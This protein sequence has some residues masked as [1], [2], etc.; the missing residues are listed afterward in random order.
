MPSRKNTPVTPIIDFDDPKSLHVAFPPKVGFG[1]VP[2]D[3][4]EYPEQMFAQ[5]D[6]M[7]LIP[8]S[9]YDARIEEADRE[10]SSLEHIRMRGNNGK[11]IESLD[12]N[13][14]GYCWAYSTTAGVML[15]RAANNQ[16]H[17]RL[18]AHAVG[19]MVKGFR[20]EGGWCGL[21]AQF[22]K[23]KGCPSVEHWKEKSMARS[24]DKPATWEN[25]AL[26]RVTE[27]YVD[28]TKQVYDRN[29]T[30]RQMAT[31]LFNNTP[32]ALDFNHWGHSVCGL[33]IVK[34]EAGSYGLLIWNSW[35][36]AWGNKGMGIL[37][38]SKMIPNGAIAQ[39]VTGASA[40]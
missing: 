7:E 5:P 27:D 33:R 28:L 35:T 15:L 34:V 18:S 4:N 12:Q 17:V 16:P 8:E 13:G 38:G 10:Q 20:D 6:E 36:D 1:L 24:N 31:C 40:A 30:E 9:E 19:C 22:Q 3:Y 25:A 26:H 2:R 11:M 32:C 29:F 21:S 39:R 37:R 14:Q 23:D